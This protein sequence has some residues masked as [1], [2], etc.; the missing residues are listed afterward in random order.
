VPLPATRTL[1][2]L[3]AAVYD[4]TVPIV[5]DGD[6]I[7]VDIPVR[8]KVR[9]D[10]IQAAELSTPKGK[11]VAAWLT[12]RISGKAVVLTLKGDYKYG[13]ERMASVSVDG[14]DVAQQM[15][16]LGLAVKWDGKGPR[17]V[18]APGPEG[19]TMP[20]DDQDYQALVTRI[21]VLE[22]RLTELETA[23]NP[24]DAGGWVRTRADNLWKKFEPYVTP[25][26]IAAVGAATLW[27]Q[28]LYHTQTTNAVAQVQAQSVENGQKADA[29]KVAASDAAGK[30][31]EVKV[32]AD[33]AVDQSVE[34]KNLLMATHAETNAKVDEVKKEVQKP[35]PLFPPKEGGKEP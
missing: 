32:V 15:I 18:G 35:R 23:G 21:V 11:T 22:A 26:I 6:T 34:N 17:P 13:G 2:L 27:L 8:E 16:D 19:G 14:V 33:K 12:D 9:I 3:P 7:W 10:G 25:L 1:T 20:A 28:S 5:H 31:A 4:A 29:A 30:V 24:G